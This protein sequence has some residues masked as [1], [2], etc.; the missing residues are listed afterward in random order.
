[1]LKGNVK[2]TLWWLSQGTVS[3]NS[4]LPLDKEFEPGRT[5]RDVLLVKHPEAQPLRPEAIISREAAQSTSKSFYIS[6]PLRTSNG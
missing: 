4:V 1:M 2:A 5:V 6:S 3:Y